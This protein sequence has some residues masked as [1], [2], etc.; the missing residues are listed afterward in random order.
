[1]LT[2]QNGILNRASEAKE[3][4]GVAQEEETQKLQEYEDT[5]NQYAP[6]SNGGNA[7]GG[8]G[9]GS[10]SDLSEYQTNDTK[11]Y[12]PDT[13]KFEKVNGTDLST[14]LVMKEKATGSEYVWVEVPKT[15]VFTTALNITEFTDDDYAKIENDLHEYTKDYRNGTDYSD[16]YAA[17]TDNV[18]WLTSD[19]YTELKN[20]MLKSVY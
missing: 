19:G 3:K 18:G 7:G 20:S 9:G 15:T 6:G 4:T 14:G 16:T 5:I 11:P 13:T 1:M 10:S 8:T 12:L 2:V 17:D